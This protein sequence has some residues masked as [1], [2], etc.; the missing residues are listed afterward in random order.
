MSR[1]TVPIQFPLE[2]KRQLD[3]LK[4]QGF[5]IAGFV[6]RAVERELRIHNRTQKG[7]A[8]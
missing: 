4:H 6:R 1:C 2:V 3:A 5:T 7:K 8:A